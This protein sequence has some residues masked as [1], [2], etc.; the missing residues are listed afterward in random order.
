MRII[1]DLEAA[2]S[3]LLGHSTVEFA[4]ALPGVKQRIREIFDED[5]TPDEAVRRI[6]SEVRTRGDHALL[7]LGRKIDG[8]G[9]AQLEV[10]KGEIAESYEKVDKGLVSA[11]QLAAERDIIST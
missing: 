7:D 11:L 10:T 2:K 6:L 8:M 3:L 4:E 1:R 9:L 5:I